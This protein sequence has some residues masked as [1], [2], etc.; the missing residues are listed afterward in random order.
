MELISHDLSE[1]YSI[2]TYRYFINNWRH[3]C[4][5]VSRKQHLNARLRAAWCGVNLADVYT[6]AQSST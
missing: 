2:F 5:L 1:P 6:A 3:L 4:F